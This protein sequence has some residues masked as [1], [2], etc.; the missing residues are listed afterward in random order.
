MP[1]DIEDV[2]RKKK[3]ADAAAAKPKFIP[4]AKREKLAAEKNKQE[5]EDRKR[6]E[7]EKARQKRENERKWEEKERQNGA[8]S[9]NDVPNGTSKVPTGPKAM[10][11]DRGRGRDGRDGGKSQKEAKKSEKTGDK[12]SATDIETN[13]LRSRYLGPEVNQQSNFSAQKKRMRTMDK[14]FN[15]DWDA[16]EDTWRDNDPLYTS[17]ATNRGGSYAG[18]GGEFDKEA[19]E[20]AKKRAR[21]VEQRDVEFGKERA[22]GIMEDFYRARDRAQERAERTGLGRRWTEKGLHEMRERDWRIMKEDFGIATKGGAMPN[23]MRNWGESGLPSRILDIVDEVGYKEP[24]PI[25]RAAIPIAQQARD[26]IGVAVTGSGKTA[27]FLLPLLV[28]ISELPDRKS[29]V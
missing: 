18:M 5:E 6:K 14:K 28:Y 15:F 29:V 22:V 27:A 4:K 19:E 25:Q 20:R 9:T 11:G 16:G 10:N 7:S 8:K 23:P 26:L 13:L 17:Q 1:L 24:T 21:M 3:A 2:L 12:R